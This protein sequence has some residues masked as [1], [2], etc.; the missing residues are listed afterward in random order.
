MSEGALALV[1]LRQL[2]GFFLRLGTLGFGGPIAL[3]QQAMADW[4]ATW[5][6]DRVEFSAKPD[7]ELVKITTEVADCSRRVFTP[8]PGPAGGTPPP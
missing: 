7:P 5:A 4:A 1:R 2:V 3:Y 6:G 8:A